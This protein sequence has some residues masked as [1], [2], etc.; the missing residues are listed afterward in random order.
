MSVEE[1]QIM[2]LM[3]ME[4]EHWRRKAFFDRHRK[5]NEKEICNS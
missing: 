1:H 2:S 3:K 5:G 4:L